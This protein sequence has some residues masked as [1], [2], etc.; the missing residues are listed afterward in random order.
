[1]RMPQFLR[2]PHRSEKRAD[3]AHDERRAGVARLTPM[4]S[5][6]RR[7]SPLL[8]FWRFA[9]CLLGHEPILAPA[10]A[11]SRNSLI[12]AHGPLTVHE[13]IPRLGCAEIDRHLHGGEEQHDL[14]AG[15]SSLSSLYSD[16]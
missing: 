15:V 14:C 13:M 10:Q 5:S 9:P 16:C 6:I 2:C 7:R 11:S 3:D 1:M 4:R 12:R 8:R